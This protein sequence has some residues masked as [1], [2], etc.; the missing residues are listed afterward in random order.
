MLR[1]GRGR[2][3][4]MD[5][6][7]KKVGKGGPRPVTPF[8][9]CATGRTPRA[10]DHLSAGGEKEEHISHFTPMQGQQLHSEF[11]PL[12]HLHYPFPALSPVLSCFF[13]EWLFTFWQRKC[14]E[15]SPYFFCPLAPHFA[16]S[17]SSHFLSLKNILFLTFN[18]VLVC[19]FVGLCICAQVIWSWRYRCL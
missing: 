19:L 13:C 7:L 12:G 15:W 6:K 3:L 1:I 5:R 17:P 2:Y 8:Q 11:R 9:L 4:N 10:Q 18:Y 14:S 16:I